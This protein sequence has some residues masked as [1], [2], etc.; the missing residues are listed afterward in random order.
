MV[1]AAQMSVERQIKCDTYTQYIEYYLALKRKEILTLV[2]THMKYEDM[3]SEISQSQWTN[4][5]CN[6]YDVVEFIET[7]LQEKEEEVGR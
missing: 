3:L 7:E 1:K 2:T 5:E 6:L 4:R